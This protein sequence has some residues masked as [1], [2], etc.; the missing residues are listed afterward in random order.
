MRCVLIFCKKVIVFEGKK[1]RFISRKM[2]NFFRVKFLEM[3]NVK[4]YALF[5]NEFL[6]I[7]IARP[8]YNTLDI[9]FLNQ[10]HQF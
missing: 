5:D 3:N 8:L 4:I 9:F 7:I 2:M 6:K 1:K 10:L